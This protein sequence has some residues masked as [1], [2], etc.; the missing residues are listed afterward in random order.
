MINFDFVSGYLYV[1]DDMVVNWWRLLDFDRNKVWQG[2]E[3]VDFRQDAYGEIINKD[4]MWWTMPVGLPA[5]KRSYEELKTIAEE[6]NDFEA[7]KALEIYLKNGEGKPRC[8]K[9]WSDFFYVPGRVA[10]TCQRILDIHYK[11][12]F[13]LEMAIMNVLHSLDY[14]EN[15]E[16]VKGIFL[17]D[18]WLTN[19]KDSREFWGVYN[20]TITFIHPFKYGF[21]QYAAMNKA[22]VKNW[23]LHI[24]NSLTSCAVS[25]SDASHK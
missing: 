16:V 18:L 4:W 25:T 13:F 3:T 20:T 23:I 14:K 8:G 10:K 22:L 5:C 15:F 6:E 11:H 7:K 24:T 2:P 1:N 19:S 9:G 17:P 21:E 12:E